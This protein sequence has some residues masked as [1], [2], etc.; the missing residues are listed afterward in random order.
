MFIYLF[1]YVCVCN[2]VN[3]PGLRFGVAYAADVNVIFE[4]TSRR[5]GETAH[6]MA[7]A[8][9]NARAFTNRKANLNMS[10]KH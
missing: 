6:F 10:R 8:N 2:M 9:G 1:V 4:V 3:A 5:N 7:A